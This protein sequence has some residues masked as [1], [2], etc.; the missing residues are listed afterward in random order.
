VIALSPEADKHVSDLESHYEALN[1]IEAVRNLILAI[2]GAKTRIA[3]SP[4]AG[5][6]APR[7]Y[8]TLKKPGRLW[9]KSGRYWI[10][11]SDTKP[12]VISGV[13]FETVDIPRWV[14]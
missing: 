7:P 12:P 9:L 3:K 13:F 11:Y 14:L 10:S 8:P 1:R 4:G 6:P 5:L 2:E